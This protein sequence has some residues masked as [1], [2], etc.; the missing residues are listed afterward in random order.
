MSIGLPT[1]ANAGRP[2]LDERSVT[3]QHPARHPGLMRERKRDCGPWWTT[4]LRD[5]SIL[6]PG[7]QSAKG[8]P[9]GN[10]TKQKLTKLAYV[11]IG[12]C[13]FVYGGLYFLL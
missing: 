3:N 8:I 4:F 1:G 13:A 6:P 11:K 7:S 5:T 10:R 9:Q 2:Y 12:N